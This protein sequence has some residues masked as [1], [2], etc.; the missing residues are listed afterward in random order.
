M[1]IDKTTAI[2]QL[3]NNPSVANQQS[4]VQKLAGPQINKPIRMLVPGGANLTE[5]VSKDQLSAAVFTWLRRVRHF[6]DVLISFADDPAK[7]NCHIS[8]VVDFNQNNKMPQWEVE[9]KKWLAERVSE[10]LAMDNVVAVKIDK[11]G[12]QAYLD[13]D[14]NFSPSSTEWLPNLVFTSNKPKGF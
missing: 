2:N 8:T 7:V 12:I 9:G 1:S 14:Q 4:L 10:V 3:G 5:L 6:K 13:Q 11:S